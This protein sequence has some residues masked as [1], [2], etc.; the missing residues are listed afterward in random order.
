MALLIQLKG[1]SNVR[2]ASFRTGEVNG[3]FHVLCAGSIAHLPTMNVMVGYNQDV[4]TLL[5]QTHSS[6]LDENKLQ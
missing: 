6:W 2:C 5:I 3:A 1:L 4:S